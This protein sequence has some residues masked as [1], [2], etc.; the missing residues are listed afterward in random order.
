MFSI[1]TF[2]ELLKG[3]PRATFDALVKQHNADK[4]SKGFGHWNH[5]VAMLYGQLSEAPGLRP[6]VAGFNGH[7]SHHY[8]LGTKPVTRTT[9]ADANKHRPDTV[10]HATASWLMGQLSGKQRRDNSEL[11]YLLDS[12]SLTLKGREF[13]QWTLANKTQNT[14]GIK[15]HVLFDA[16][17]QA[18]QWHSFSA[19]NVNDIELAREVPL[20]R[21]ALYVFDKGYCDYRWWHSIDQAG[22]Y[23]VTR[24]KRNASLKHVESRS[25]PDDAAQ[26][27][28]KDEIVQFKNRNPGGGRKN[29]YTQSLR[30]VTIARPDRDPMV[31]A[32]NDLHSP[33]LEI[34]QRYKERWGIEL[35]FKWIKQHLR[36]KKF[37]GRS[38][39]AVRI[40]VLTALICYLLLALYRQRHAIAANMWECLALVRATLFQRQQ[41]ESYY[42]KKRRRE[43]EI[44]SRQLRLI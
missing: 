6:L 23:F 38:E 15:V 4:Y 30:C 41:T 42:R 32:T 3:L 7:A 25:I 37:L 21:G 28:L 35:F 19:A 10:F 11:M 5:M 31:L 34:A 8:H 43:D 2:H 44:A 36:I 16:A 14:Q 17:S 33:A 40:Q 12:T 26:V 1:T 29:P 22:A 18:P 9:L 13:D 39:N 20:Q 27:V 24:F